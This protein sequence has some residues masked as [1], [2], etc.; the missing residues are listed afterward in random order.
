MQ[1]ILLLGARNVV[2]WSVHLAYRRPFIGSPVP[3]TLGV[4]VRAS[5]SHTLE[6]EAGE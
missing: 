2:Q 5:D 4:V 3:H 1:N 6:L